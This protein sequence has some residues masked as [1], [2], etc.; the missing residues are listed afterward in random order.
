MKAPESTAATTSV[1]KKPPSS[2]VSDNAAPTKRK[3]RLWPA[4]L[5]VVAFWAFHFGA[6]FVEMSMGFRFLSRFAFYGIIVLGFVVWWLAASRANWKDRLLVFGAMIAGAVIAG[7]LADKKSLGS[8]GPFGVFLSGFPFVLSVWTA[9]LVVTEKWLTNLSPTTWR[10]VL[11]AAILLTWGFFDLVRWEGLDGGQHSA[12]AWR[13][14]PTAE[15]RFLADRK[16]TS[17]KTKVVAAALQLQP[18]DWPEFRGPQRNSQTNDLHLKTD[19]QSQ[20]PKLVWRHRVGPGWSSV[21][22]VDGRLFTQEQRGEQEGTV[23]YD[24]ATG[25]ELWSHADSARFFEPLSGAGPRGT[26]TFAVGKIYSLG[27]TGKLNCLEAATG[28]V[29]WAHDITLDADAAVASGGFGLRQWG[30]SNSPLV[31]SGT[32]IV[33]AGGEHEKNVLAYRADNGD[34]K[35][36]APAGKDGYSSPQLVEFAGQPQLVMHTG[37][38][39]NAF[40]LADGKPLWEQPCHADMFLP[41]TQPQ[42]IGADQLIAQSEEGIQLVKLTR[43]GDHWN[44][45]QAWDS[46]SLKPSLNDYVVHDGSIYGFDDGVFCCLDAQTGKRRWKA[47]RYGHGQVL[48]VAD[49][50]LLLAM[51]ETGEAILLAANPK[52]L[53]ELGRFQAIE[54]KTWN[55]PIVA[56]GRLYARNGE[57]MAC[58]DLPTTTAQ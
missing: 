58:Y 15:D 57:E 19:W 41:V 8:M 25:N 18:G 20:A 50:G 32:V 13:W 5:L 39:L 29:V 37:A 27:A 12:F 24:A 1:P 10:T 45:K 53:E 16:M 44:A 33:F 17:S 42:P 49:Q 34:L 14:T 40:D 38:G 26:P 46:K 30:Y 51:T 52:K 9:W 11:C 47:G 6:D 3:L 4:I 31:T 36:I 35:W 56:H 54:G 2:H 43:D 48:L 7:L 21:I 22:I 55:H 28:E 23:C